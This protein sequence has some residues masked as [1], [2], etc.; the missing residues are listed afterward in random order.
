ME[1]IVGIIIGLIVGGAASWLV[2]NARA[3]SDLASQQADYREEIAGL[4]GKLEQSDEAQAILDAAKEQLNEAF[5]STA[6]SAL[7]NNNQAFLTLANE[8]LGK[9]LESAKGELD[10]RHQQFQELV[11]PLAENYGKLN[12]Q[13]ETLTTQVQ[14]VTAETARLSGALT[15]NRQIGNWG[16]VQLHRVVELAGMV[17]YCVHFSHPTSNTSPS[18]QQ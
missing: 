10:R 8:N 14:S 18:S 16:E 12:P 7:Q 1:W 9:T 2:R 17:E 15:D 13:I 4:K 11:K 3:K 6:S 5:K